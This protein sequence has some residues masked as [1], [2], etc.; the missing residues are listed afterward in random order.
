MK[1][2]QAAIEESYAAQVRLS[3]T[4]P[5]PL[6]PKK[7]AAIAASEKSTERMP[8]S[9][10]RPHSEARALRSGQTRSLATLAAAE[11]RSHSAANFRTASPHRHSP[12]LSQAA[13]HSADT[14]SPPPPPA[15]RSGTRARGRTTRTTTRTPR[16]R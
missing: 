14:R 7:N 1:K 13:E 5:A 15:S 16:A 10:S 8:Q 6:R 2:R 11:G 12:W 3:S 4:P 9:I